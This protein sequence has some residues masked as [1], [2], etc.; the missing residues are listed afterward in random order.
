MIF[1]IAT[2]A[3]MPLSLLGQRTTGAVDVLESW[4]PYIENLDHP[5]DVSNPIQGDQTESIPRIVNFYEAAREGRYQQWEPNVAGGT[6]LATM[7]F[8]GIYSPLNWSHIAL[9]HWYATTLRAALAL[10]VAQVGTFV[11]LRSLGIGRGAATVGA[12]SF[13]FSGATIVFLQRITVVFVFPLLVHA[14]ERVVERI[15]AGRIAWLAAVVAWCWLE[16]FPTGFVYAI[17]AAGAWSLTRVVAQRV[18]GIEDFGASV[19]RLGAL[20]LGLAWGL[21]VAA[22]AIVPFMGHLAESGLRDAREFDSTSHLDSIEAF[23]LFSIRIFGPLAEPVNTFGRSSVANVT[24]LGIVV[25][26][27]V[28]ATLGA[29]ALGRLRLERPAAIAV[30]YSS[31]LATVVYVLVYLGGPLLGAAYSVPG[32]G[33]GNLGRSR[34][35]LAFAAAVVFAIGIDSVL[36][37]RGERASM[38]VRVPAGMPIVVI[39]ASLAIG[40]PDL[41]DQVGDLEDSRGVVQPVAV[42]LAIGLIGLGIV[43]ATVRLARRRSEHAVY[44][45]GTIVVIVWASV[46]IPMRDFT[47]Q[48]PVDDFYPRL[49]AHD[50]LAELTGGE[51]R[52]TAQGAHFYPS[53]SQTYELA[54][55]RGTAVHSERFERTLEQ[56]A[57]TAFERD[58]IKILMTSDEWNLTSPI[59][60][61]MAVRYYVAPTDERPFGTTLALAG[62]VEEWI[63]I[64]EHTIPLDVDANLAGVIVAIS[65]IGCDD[66]SVTVSLRDGSTLLDTTFRPAFE[67]AEGSYGFAIDGSGP[68]TEP[69]LTVTAPTDCSVSL[70]VSS[71]GVPAVT[72]IVDD[73]ADGVRLV[74]TESAWIYEREAALR[75]VTAHADWTVAPEETAPAEVAGRAPGDTRP[76]VSGVDAPSAGDGTATVTQF[77]VGDDRVVADVEATGPTMLVVAQNFSDG[78]AATVDGVSA[79]V[80]VANGWSMAVEVPEGTSRVELEYRPPRFAVSL[81]ASAVGLLALVAVACSAM[82]RRL[83]TK[84]RGWVE[85]KP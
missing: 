52:Y 5:P 30:A 69:A 7:P 54:D 15:T 73:P 21:V 62:D 36:T 43:F 10:F 82:L 53:S 6:P 74:A 57:P 20:T 44:A 75:I 61:A 41:V 84:D 16:G 50:T 27:V 78:W 8:D 19:R 12:V 81:L 60:D 85:P 34:F 79:P 46:A 32:L 45:Y 42:E 13:G 55:L 39:G 66:G 51:Y 77:D 40:L 71:G 18:A 58:P 63:E 72:T 38:S 14:C 64:D 35:L 26:A 24:T 29:V 9:P 4:S 83:R 23:G 68:L 3:F 67:I 49:E 22:V 59:L 31:V 76:V 11:F 70:G 65:A 80:H 33:D 1:A 25:A 56:A 47:P 28:L 37:S 2:F 48:A 17:A